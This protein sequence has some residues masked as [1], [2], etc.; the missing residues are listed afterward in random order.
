MSD[1]NIIQD[2]TELR[3]L[4]AENPDL[5]IVVM[6]GEEAAVEGWC[7][8]YCTNVRCEVGEVLDCE[9]PWEPEKVYNDKIEFEEDLADY[10]LEENEDRHHRVTDA[11]LE[12][13]LKV[14]KDTYSQYWRKAIIVRAD[15]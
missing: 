7:Y 13:I 15:N 6:V 5:P 11:Q 14:W 8:T 4:I 10:I 12:R 3:K 2:S 9:C 1:L